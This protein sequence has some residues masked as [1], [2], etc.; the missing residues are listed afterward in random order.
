MVRVGG[1]H[2]EP[3]ACLSLCICKFPLMAAEATYPGNAVL[4]KDMYVAM[5]QEVS[6]KSFREGS[7]EPLYL[8]RWGLRPVYSENYSWG[9]ALTILMLI[10]V[11]ILEQPLKGNLA[12][13][14]MMRA[15]DSPTLSVCNA[16]PTS[17]QIGKEGHS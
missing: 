13:N 1:V 14:L 11:V 3:F 5:R 9:F 10:P 4:S 15:S 17:F 6:E 16:V 2:L 12:T 7:A 8:D